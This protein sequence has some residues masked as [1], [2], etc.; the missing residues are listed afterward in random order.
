M[1][2]PA[3]AFTKMCIFIV[4]MASVQWALALF[5]LLKVWIFKK[6]DVIGE[7]L[8]YRQEWFNFMLKIIPKE[9]VAF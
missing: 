8:T 5:C 3:P 1:E 6:I 9:L 7:R 2:G 4:G